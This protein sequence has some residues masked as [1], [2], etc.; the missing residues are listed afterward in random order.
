MRKDFLASLILLGIAGAYYA[1]GSTIAQSTL[2]DNVGPRGL[3]NV[4]TAVLVAI[5]L[6]MG[7]RA[8]LAPAENATAP[9]EA[10]TAKEAE[11]PWPRAIGLFLIAAL[12]IPAASV[13]GYAV[14]LVLLLTAVALY[15]G[16]KPS[17]R[18]FAVAFG[19]AAFFWLLFDVVLG[20]RQPEGLLF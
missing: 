11:A 1:A 14:A 19:G 5:A 10:E 9:G 8:L 2:S 15:E 13:L 16:M 18:L 7:A 20:V 12:Y 4:L 3:P 6:A 17:W